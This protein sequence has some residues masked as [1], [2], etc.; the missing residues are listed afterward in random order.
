MGNL[1]R[2]V[3]NWNKQKDKH[4]HLKLKFNRYKEPIGITIFCVNGTRCNVGS[5]ENWTKFRFR[6]RSLTKGM[7]QIVSDR[8]QPN[9]ELFESEKDGMLVCKIN[10]CA[11]KLEVSD[12][13][14]VLTEL[15]PEYI[16]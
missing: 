3:H 12:L 6:L 10:G 9:R 1:E 7:L 2:A 15:L 11:E 14:K 16:I 4:F 13:E 5:I 8:D